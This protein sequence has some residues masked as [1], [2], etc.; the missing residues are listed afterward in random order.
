[1]TAFALMAVLA[2]ALVGLSRQINGRLALATSPL[3]AAYFNRSAQYGMVA[4][5]L[6]VPVMGALVMPAGVVAALLLFL[7]VG[8][9][10]RLR[11]QTA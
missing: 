9:L 1:M 4:N 8:L 3:A 6:V 10:A 2:G 7:L 5:L 11:P